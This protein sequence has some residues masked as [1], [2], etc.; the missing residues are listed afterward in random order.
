M[1]LIA[2]D[3]DYEVI[4]GQIYM[5]ARPNMNH[6]SIAGNIY[7]IF[8]R[9]LKSKVCKTYM[10][11]DLFLDDENNVI[12]DVV[13][14][15]DINKKKYKG[16]YGAPD[17][18]VEVLSPSTAKR[19]ISEKKDLY[20][21][22]GVKEYWAVRPESKEIT[23]YYLKDKYLVINN[24]YY[25]RTLEE[26][27]EMTEADKKAIVSNFNVSLFDDLEINLEEVFEE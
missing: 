24:I 9:F 25:Y 19:D 15:C 11:P 8:K 3:K 27:D 14:L 2:D 4:N 6:V 16:I 26:L 17:L 5:K 20:E 7:A 23:V 18:V 10:E 1:S 22:Y 13:I 12:P 21:K